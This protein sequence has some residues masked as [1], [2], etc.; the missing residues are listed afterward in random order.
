MLQRVPALNE[1][2]GDLDLKQVAQTAAEMILILLKSSTAPLPARAPS[3]D[4]GD[5]RPQEAEAVEA[6][7]EAEEAAA[8]GMPEE[9]L[10]V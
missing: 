7:K 3:A 6:E 1:S 8:E 10:A 4:P 5:Q 9:D 2:T